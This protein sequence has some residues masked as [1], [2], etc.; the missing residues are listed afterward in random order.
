M[1]FGE[2]SPLHL[3]HAFITH[4]QNSLKYLLGSSENN[5]QD[6][7]LMSTLKTEHITK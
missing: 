4:K 1:P 6:T 3:Q 7:R 2:S 5:F